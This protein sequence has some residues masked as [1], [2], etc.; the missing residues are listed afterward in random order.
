MN[1]VFFPMGFKYSTPASFGLSLISGV[2]FSLMIALP[3]L[4]KKSLTPRGTGAAVVVGTSLFLGTGLGGFVPLIVFFVS[5]TLLSKAGK[6]RKE[7]LSR[8]YAEHSER[9]ARQV[10]ANGGPAAA[11]ALLFGITGHPV[12]LMATGAV[13]AAAN[14]DTWASEGGVLFDAPTRLITTLKPVERGESGGV[15]LPGTLLSAAGALLI[16]L[17]CIWLMPW[18]TLDLSPVIF[19]LLISLTGFLGSIVDSILGATVQGI[20]THKNS[21]T[22]R[23]FSQEGRENRKIRGFHF[24]TNST[25]NFLSGLAVFF[26]AILSG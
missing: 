8:K 3:G 23:R 10:F 9:T 13:L 12:F 6:K 2:L 24:I 21:Y 11:S 4:K 18:R 1:P 19:V 16:A 17:V 5:S 26:M 15:S 20:Y 14:A 7:S 25:V 22:E